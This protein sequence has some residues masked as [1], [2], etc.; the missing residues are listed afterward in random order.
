MVM[1]AQLSEYS[2]TVELYILHGEICD[3]IQFLK[4]KTSGEK[5]AIIIKVEG[6]AFCIRNC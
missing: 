5:N 6:S 3:I 1:F 4:S 2:K